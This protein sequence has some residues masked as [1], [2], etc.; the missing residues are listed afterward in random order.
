MK[1]LFICRQ[2]T[3]DT[4][5]GNVALARVWR[6]SGREAAVLF[7]GEALAA[8]SA[9]PVQW[10]PL[11]QSRPARMT[12]SR[13]AERLGLPLA[14]PRDGRW[15]D[16][17]RLL[18]ETASAGVPLWACPIWSALLGI[19]SPPEGLTAISRE[20]LLEELAASDMVVGGY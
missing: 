18:R 1:A 16:V 13:N 10:S 2:G 8:L 20:R 7:T 3:E 15:T 17:R 6:E 4:V 9:G 19:E 5:V 12:I 14:D 11:F